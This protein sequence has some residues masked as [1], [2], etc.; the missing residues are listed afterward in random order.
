MVILRNARHTYSRANMNKGNTCR[1]DNEVLKPTETFKSPTI[2]GDSEAQ[3][4]L[5]NCEHRC[6]KT[7]NLLDRLIVEAIKCS[8]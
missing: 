3:F 6:N 7:T 2:S 1:H 4:Q 8:F 5:I